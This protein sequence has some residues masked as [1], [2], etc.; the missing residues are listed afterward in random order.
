M[1]GRWSL[2]TFEFDHQ[3]SIEQ[4]VNAKAEL[5]SFTLVRKWH[6]PLP[7]NGD[8]LSTESPGEYLL[9]GRFE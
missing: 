8:A 4:E 1:N 7:F 3:L 2:N 6:Q 5:D 9:I